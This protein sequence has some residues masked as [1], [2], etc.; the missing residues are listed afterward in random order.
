M[1]IITQKN[2]KYDIIH[3]YKFKKVG[4]KMGRKRKEKAYRKISQGVRI[5]YWIVKYF[6]DNNINLSQTVNNLLKQWIKD[7][8]NI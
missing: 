7:R 5:E 6:R 2:K 3:N 1:N 4:F 8:H